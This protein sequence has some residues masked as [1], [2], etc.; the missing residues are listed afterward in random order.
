M[1][2][3]AYNP[4]AR[5][6][7][8]QGGMTLLL[9]MF[10]LTSIGNIYRIIFETNQAIVNFFHAGLKESLKVIE[11]VKDSSSIGEIFTKLF[12]L[13]L[14]IWGNF[15]YMMRKYT[16]IVLMIIGPVCIALW[17]IPQTKHAFSAWLKE[18]LGTVFVQSIHALL[19][20]IVSIMAKGTTSPMMMIVAYM[21]FIPTGKALKGIFGLNSNMLGSL[22]SAG[23]NMGMGALMTM[24]GAAKS[25]KDGFIQSRN[26]ALANVD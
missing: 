8:I 21:I 18:L 12:M 14:M 20:M 9:V 19:F 24:Y 22:H 17:L 2:S 16:L 6:E 10:L 13:G 4:T 25:A 5:T 1:A 11:P 15:Y 23:A 3:A 7:A 26:S